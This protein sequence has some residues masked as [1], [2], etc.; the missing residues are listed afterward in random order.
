MALQFRYP[1][2]GMTALGTRIYGVTTGENNRCRVLGCVQEYPAAPNKWR[3][4]ASPDDRT[5]PAFD[6]N[7]GL[8]GVEPSQEG[9]GSKR[10]AAVWL[11][12]ASDA[13]QTWFK[14]S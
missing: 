7:N 2:H 9:F 5:F 14:E 8:W 3:A 12:G 10:E 6:Y 1:N 11:L 13:R 4:V